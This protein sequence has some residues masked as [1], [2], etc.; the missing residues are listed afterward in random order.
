MIIWQSVRIALRGIAANKLRSG[1]TMLGIIIGVMS[2]IAMLSIG[3]G[4]QNTVTAQINSIGT[5]LLFIRPGNT[6]EGGVRQNESAAT[7]TLGDADALS[8]V[9]NVT[10]VAPEVDGFGQVAYLGN[11]AV[12]RVI[13]VTPEY[14]DAM[15]VLFPVSF[16]VK[17][18]S[19]RE[20]SND[21]VVM[22]LEGL[23]WSDNMEEFS[24]EDKGAWK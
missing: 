16:K 21:Y 19:K 8:T 14:Q 6:Q 3:R 4:M 17:F 13:G 24:I 5:N 1:L 10:S 12:G 18:I 15:N 11:N 9:D 7:L 20:K 23:W 2:V 22:P